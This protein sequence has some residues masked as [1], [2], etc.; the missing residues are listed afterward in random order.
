MD[1]RHD[2]Q[3][4]ADE[5]G[6]GKLRIQRA[7]VPDQHDGQA[8]GLGRLVGG[9]QEINTGEA[10]LPEWF[11]SLRRAFPNWDVYITP[12]LNDE[13]YRREREWDD[14]IADLQ[15]H[16][17]ADLHLATSVRSFRTP[18]LAAF[19][20]AVLDADTD[21]A[22][23][24]Y[25]R[26]KDKYPI[27]LTRDL[28][29]AKE[30]VRSQCQGTTR[31]GLLASSGALRLKPEGIFVKNEISVANWFLNGKDDVRSS[32][33]LEDVVTE[34]D[35]QGLELDYSI[36]AWDA[37]F[38]F[39]GEQWTYNSFTGSSWNSIKSEDRKLYLKNACRVLLT[40]ARQG[41]V[42]FIPEGSD[43]DETRKREWYDRTYEYLHAV[44]IPE[45]R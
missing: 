29:K 21:A 30:W 35:I 11:D 6:R 10:G 22:K 23:E 28:N 19:V 41:M 3:V 12:Q 9:G 16:E 31:Y 15:I 18:D 7:G 25:A 17:N 1:E 26:I 13:E 39:D 45:L 14:M 24:L 2:R 37:D 20:K 32:Y 43:T 40:R 8:S 38:R 34:F 4:H 27:V 42:I 44:G 5:K 33:Y 36:V